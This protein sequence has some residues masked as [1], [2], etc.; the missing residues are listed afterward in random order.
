MLAPFAFVR[1]LDSSSDSDP[2]IKPHKQINQYLL[3]KTLGEGSYAKVFLG[4]DTQTKQHYAMK[5]FRLRELQR[6]H[7]GVSQLEREISAMR[8]LIHPN[9]IR[10]YEVLHDE[11]N[12]IV[13]LVID[14][15][16]CGS[17]D[18]IL[19]GQDHMHK[20]LIRMVFRKVLSAVSYL[21]SRGIVHQ[22]IKPSNIL[23]SGDGAIYLSDFGLGHSFQST[24]MVVG[25]PAYQA[26][27]ALS[28]PTDDG[29]TLDPSKEDVWSLGVTLFQCLFLELPFQ[30][31]NV[32]EIIQRITHEPLVI[33][34]GI[35]QSLEDLLRGML[36][37]DP[38][39][40]MS[41]A[42]VTASSFFR[43]SE[44][45]EEEI[46]HLSHLADTPVPTLP[47]GSVRAIRATVCDVGY[48]FARLMWT[49]INGVRTSKFDSCF[50]G[51][52]L[53][54]VLDDQQ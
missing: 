22:D 12:A 5:R 28:D 11:G 36:M 51:Q 1:R 9:I 44:E 3:L 29:D 15:A 47:V 8:R 10:L 49:A 46:E 16:D 30:G 48:S 42:E 39:K 38:E 41:V 18:R 19:L 20:A 33:P 54:Y 43:G 26:P 35:D 2:H 24:E 34:K 25:S 40:R 21:H 45:E 37:V 14:Y 17:L 4:F 6:L 31:E 32:F 27:E 52:G 7:A 53:K 50:L 23:L 13:Y